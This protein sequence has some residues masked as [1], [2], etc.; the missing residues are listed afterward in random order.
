MFLSVYCYYALINSYFIVDMKRDV[1]T[2]NL[3]AW[4]DEQVAV[5]DC[6]ERLQGYDY[7]AIVDLDE[8]IVPKARNNLKDLMVFSVNH[9]F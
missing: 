1:G 7:V 5:F 3:L 2:K 6:Y 8:F 9:F 4:Q